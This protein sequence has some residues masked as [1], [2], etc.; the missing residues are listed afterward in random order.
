MNL[1]DLWRQI[2]V[3]SGLLRRSDT[4]L[5]CLASRS[6][7]EFPLIEATFE[8]C[9]TGRLVSVPSLLQVAWRRGRQTT[10]VS[11]SHITQWAFG[12]VAEE[13]EYMLVEVPRARFLLLLE[14]LVRVALTGVL[15]KRRDHQRWVASAPKHV[16]P[17]FYT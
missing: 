2:Q 4:R 16:R 7:E 6:L 11:S 12:I 9:E 5:L 14:E 13:G 3:H 10:M 15:R 1:R 8:G 17:V